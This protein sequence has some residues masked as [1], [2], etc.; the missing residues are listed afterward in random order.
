MSAV[1]ARRAEMNPI[2]TLVKEHEAI[3]KV[4]DA[5]EQEGIAIAEGKSFDSAKVRKMLDFIRRFAYTCHCA[6]EEQCLFRTMERYGMPMDA[7]PI[8]VML[9]EHDLSRKAVG[10]I[11]Y[12]LPMA[13]RGDKAQAMILANA[14]KKYAM[15]ARNYIRMENNVLFPMAR[16]MLKGEDVQALEQEFQGIDFAKIGEGGH[17]TFH[18]LA[19]ELAG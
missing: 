4:I 18:R 5:L 14:I 7:G 11:I 13:E 16:R 15:L 10:S 17:E 2:D 1:R 6:K 3:L 12:A 19:L 8:A 9:H